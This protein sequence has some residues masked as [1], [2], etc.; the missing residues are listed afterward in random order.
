MGLAVMSQVPTPSQT[1]GPLFGF[2]LL[3]EGSTQ[4]ADP[5]DRDAE[6]V[7]GYI[8]DGDGCAL[9]WPDALV[10]AWHDEQFGRAQTDENGEFQFCV[11]RPVTRKF[12]DGSVEA[13]HLHVAVFARG[14]LKQVQTRMYFPD[15][16][17]NTRDTVLQSVPSDRRDTLIARAEGGELRFDVILQG[18]SETVFFDF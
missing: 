4:M 9:A 8:I 3:F 12:E 2:A 11:K 13:P 15:V 7:R 17:A 14:L 16:A 5:Q 10:E 6:W 1:C 18:E